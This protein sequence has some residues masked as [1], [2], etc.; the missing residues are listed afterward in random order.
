MKRYWFTLLLVLLLF[1]DCQGF[2]NDHAA[3]AVMGHL[4]RSNTR[5]GPNRLEA[6]QR[7]YN[8]LMFVYRPEMRAWSIIRDGC[9]WKFEPRCFLWMLR[10]CLAEAFQ[11]ISSL[12][13]LKSSPGDSHRSGNRTYFQQPHS[14]ALLPM[15]RAPGF[16]TQDHAQARDSNA[17]QCNT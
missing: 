2:H 14:S 13:L 5:S 8:P 3:A 1:F 16:A 6:Q 15:S 4:I 17:A 12:R 10:S 7:I 9:P 11:R